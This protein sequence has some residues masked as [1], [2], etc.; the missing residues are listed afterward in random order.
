MLADIAS[1]NT[2][3]ADVLFL[4]AAIAFGLAALIAGGF[5]KPRAT[6]WE[7]PLAL[8]ALCLVSIGWLVL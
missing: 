6:P 4:I 3:T 1:G 5:G 7:R 2:D 8:A